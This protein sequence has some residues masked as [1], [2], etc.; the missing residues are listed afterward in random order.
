MTLR[1]DGWESVTPAGSE[2]EYTWRLWCDTRRPAHADVMGWQGD[3]FLATF[4]EATNG[5]TG[6]TMSGGLG[7]RPR[8]AHEQ[9]AWFTATEPG[10]PTFIGIQIAEG[11]SD[12]AIETSR[13]RIESQVAESYFGYRFFA[14]P[15]REG[16]DLLAVTGTA[17]DGEQ[18][19]HS[20]STV[21][22]RLAPQ[23]ADFVAHKN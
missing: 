5:A 18:L 3:D 8:H 2:G 6:A 4:I 16:E 13:R 11:V 19:R 22:E 9:L 7:S 20:G 21:A 15:L 1:E 10:F 14:T 23:T 17:P 12:V